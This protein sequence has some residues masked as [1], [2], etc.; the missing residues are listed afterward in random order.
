MEIQNLK[1]SASDKGQSF[2]ESLK[3]EN[4]QLHDQLLL[5]EQTIERLGQ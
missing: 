4:D 1:R 5:K 2:V 3:L